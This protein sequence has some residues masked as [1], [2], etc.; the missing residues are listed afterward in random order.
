MRTRFLAVLLVLPLQAA[1]DRAGAAPVAS[2]VRDSAG[3]RVVESTAPAWDGASVWRIADTPS[4]VVGREEGA[5]EDQFYGVS[6]VVRFPDGRIAIANAGTSEI[7]IHDPA[8]RHLSTLGREGDGPGE[9]RGLDGLWITPGDSL[10]AYDALRKQLTTF[11]PSGRVASTHPLPVVAGR[12]GSTHLVGRFGDGSVL[13]K[14]G[15]PLA[16]NAGEGLL[17]QSAVYGR[18]A[19]DGSPA[20]AVGELFDGEMFVERVDGGMTGYGRPCA[21]EPLAA[22]GRDGFHYSEGGSYEIRRFAPGG[23]LQMIVRRRADPL[24]V[25]AADLRSHRE[26][27]LEGVAGP[28]RARLER[29]LARVPIP[30]TKPAHGRMMVDADANLWVM[31]TRAADDEAPRWDVFGPGGAWLGTVDLPPRTRLMEVGRD[32]VVVVSYAEETNVEEVRVHRLERGPGG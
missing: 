18:A 6:S 17:R 21:A 26:G 28:D 13:A 2:V 9:F 27:M 20:R 32:H 4:V 14:A 12:P 31:R 5:R 10:V 29:F 19:L 16:P 8:G 1:C 3:V 25:T 30:E 22:V 11:D 7:R 23:A 15:T 24:P